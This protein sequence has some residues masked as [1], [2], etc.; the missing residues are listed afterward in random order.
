MILELSLCV[1]G[2]FHEVNQFSPIHNICF[3]SKKIKKIKKS[4]NQFR[5]SN[6]VLMVPKG[7]FL[8]CDH[9]IPLF[10]NHIFSKNTFCFQKTK[11]LF[12]VANF[13]KGIF[14]SSKFWTINFFIAVYHS[15]FL[16]VLQEIKQSA[17]QWNAGIHW[18]NSW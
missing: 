17:I 14:P 11:M 7:P 5:C 13:S 18:S 2:I 15:R 16:L 3:T 8:S 12:I 6:C 1:N 9:F 4:V 10:I